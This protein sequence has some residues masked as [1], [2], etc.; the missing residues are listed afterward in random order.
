MT[1]A[2]PRGLARIHRL[3]DAAA[4]DPARARLVIAGDT[5]LGAEL[6]RGLFAERPA[7]ADVLASLE[8]AGLRGRGGAGFPT[9]VKWRAVAAAAGETIVVA[10]GHEGEP[11]SAKDRW[12]LVH[13]PFAVLDG[14][15]LAAATV[16]ASRAIVYVSH[17][18][19]RECVVAAADELREAGLVPAG[20]S[21]EVFAVSGGYVAGEETAVCRALNGGPALPLAKPPRPFERGV[22]G[23]PTLVSNVETLASASWITIHGADAFRA[24]GTASSPGTALFTLAAGDA[25][26]VVVEAP[27]GVT[28][29][30]LCMTVDPVPPA[31]STVLMGGWF[32][33]ILHGDL[34]S[35]RCSYEDVAAAGSGLGCAAITV[36]DPHADLLDLA[37]ELAEWYA[38]ESAQQCGV[39]RNGTKSIHQAL[40][41]MQGGAD[42]V[43]HLQNLQRWG[44]TLVHRGACSFLD[45]AA[46][47]ARTVAPRLADHGTEKEVRP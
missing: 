12:L 3:P 18:Q 44:Q 2:P 47:L 21:L 34:G 38:A 9:H 41:S 23:R 4:L 42:P 5:G 36:L 11:A 45:G 35:L 22:D 13:R 24:V 29:A 6:H 33:G 10:N 25:S 15:L 46:A 37:V 32:G 19:A 16:H 43:V 14:L 31:S 27:L 8:A 17:E 26:P 30:T 39:C 7:P 40:R 28:L 20:V 1:Q